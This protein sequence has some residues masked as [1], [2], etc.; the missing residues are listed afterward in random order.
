MFGIQ[1]CVCMRERTRKKDS[2]SVRL[3]ACVYVHT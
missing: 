1:L 3:G 2:V